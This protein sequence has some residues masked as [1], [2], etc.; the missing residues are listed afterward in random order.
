MEPFLTA[1][2]SPIRAPLAVEGGFCKARQ[3]Q[4]GNRQFTE[5]AVSHQ[6]M[7]SGGGKAQPKS[8]GPTGQG[9]SRKRWEIGFE[10]LVAAPRRGLRAS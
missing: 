3:Q 1:P 2:R 6:A 4:L 10:S 9:G 5:P 7:P 8:L